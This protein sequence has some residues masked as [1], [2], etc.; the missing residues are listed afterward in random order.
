M[1][2]REEWSAL[3]LSLLAGLSTV[4]GA[5]LAIIVRPGPA[6]LGF[7]LG[8]AIGVMGLLSIVELWIK[9]A[10]DNGV[11][12]VTLALAVGAG[13][14]YIAHPY[15]PD[16]EPHKNENETSVS[17]SATAAQADD[18]TAEDSPKSNA[19]GSSRHA[20]ASRRPL[21]KAVSQLQAQRAG[22]GV[23]PRGSEEM[24]A[25]SQVAEGTKLNDA[26]SDHGSDRSSTSARTANLLRLGSL[27]ALTMT[28]HNA[29]E[30]FAVAFASFTDLG[31][32]M[33]LAI[34]VHNIPEGIIVAAPVFAATG[35]RW[36]AIGLAF[37]SG[38]SEPVGALIA[39]LLFQS[40]LT[41]LVVHLMLAFVGGIM[42][43]VC[44]TELWTEGRKC[45]H[46]QHLAAG[47]VFGAAFIGATLFFV[48]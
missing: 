22:E 45:K 37:A 38:L 33:A 32:T 17:K 10:V 24:S 29:P 35:K 34:A 1:F 16:F 42:L 40:F 8:V 2:S 5:I 23:E 31:P 41:E 43:A 47:I 39:L 21:H 48:P 28:L 12:S 26:G 11:A 46:D 25:S 4:L 36:Q 7:L 18:D 20:A 19:S 13:L 6:L 30:G 15:F 9:N 3:L 27:M 14:Y 44:C